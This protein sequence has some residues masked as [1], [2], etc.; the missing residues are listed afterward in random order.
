[1]AVIIC[2]SYRLFNW[3]GN[4]GPGNKYTFRISWLTNGPSK[5]NLLFMDL[6]EGPVNCPPPLD[7]WH[8][9]ELFIYLFAH[10]GQTKNWNLGSFFICQPLELRQLLY[11]D[12]LKFAL[13]TQ[14][15]CLFECV[16]QFAKKEQKG[17]PLRRSCCQGAALIFGVLEIEM[18]FDCEMLWAQEFF[19]TLLLLGTIGKYW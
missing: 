11:P 1:M 6:V 5:S 18:R 12:S 10:S 16:R 2:T 4:T 15:V 13:S 19:I 17:K 9:C 8:S 14:D 7:T 3:P